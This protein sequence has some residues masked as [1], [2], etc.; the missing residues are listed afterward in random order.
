MASLFPPKSAAAAAKDAISGAASKASP[1]AKRAAK[2]MRL[3]GRRKRDSE[4][5]LWDRVED[6]EDEVDGQK[7]A[8]T[9]PETVEDVLDN[10]EEM[11]GGR[12]KMD[13]MGRDLDRK[14][15]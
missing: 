4:D 1:F 12:E 9:L 10:L 13:Q 6:D 15:K 14:I 7:R 2:L 5:D 3:S 11:L 8:R